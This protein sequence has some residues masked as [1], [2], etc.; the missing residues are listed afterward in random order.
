MCLVMFVSRCY[1][2]KIVLE[3]FWRVGWYL[4]PG[5]ICFFLSRRHRE[6]SPQYHLKLLSGINMIWKY[7][8]VSVLFWVIRFHGVNPLCLNPLWRGLLGHP[9]FARLR[10]KYFSPSPWEV[11]ES[12]TPPPNFQPPLPKLKISEEKQFLL[13][14]PPPWFC[15][16]P[17]PLSG[18]SLV[19]S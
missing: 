12:S 2:W 11:V 3:I 17:A 9:L 18:D 5:K 7:T 10:I 8:T 15:F 1:I 14:G 16:F 4:P 19:S 13:P 6:Q